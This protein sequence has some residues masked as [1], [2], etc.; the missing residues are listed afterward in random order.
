MPH[1]QGLSNNSYP[2]SDHPNPRI[3]TYLSK[4]NSNIVFLKVSLL[5][6]E[7]IKF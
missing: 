4:I 1:S 2:E 7:V 5:K 6:V 3:G